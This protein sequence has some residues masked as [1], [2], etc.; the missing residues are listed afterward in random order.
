MSEPGRGV[1]RDIAAGMAQ[2]TLHRIA[3]SAL[4]NAQRNRRHLERGRSI[5]A[6]RGASLGK[7]DSAVIVAAG[8]SVHRHD[9]V[10]ELIRGGY[11][12]AVIATDS[13]MRGC[14]RA[15]LV[16]DLVVTVDPHADRIVRWFGR[17]DLHDGHLEDDYFRRQDM[18]RGFANERR[19]NDEIVALLDRYGSSMRIAL[20]TSAS[21]AVVDRAL[22]TG[23][24]IFWWNPMLD[25]PA[26]DGMSRRLQRLN[27]LPCINAGGNVG[28][29]CWMIADAVLG[30]SR[31]A[32]TGVDFSYYGDTPRSATQYYRELLDLLGEARLDEGFVDIHNPHLDAPFYTDP[33][34]LWY[35]DVFLELLADAECETW[36]CT[37]GGILFGEGIR[38]DTLDSFISLTNAS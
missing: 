6:L 4:E 29:A 9:P 8:P 2:I 14:L 32:L 16:P 28:T 27:G 1:G 15:G 33:A 38:W 20:S 35:R 26:Q 19:A 10:G 17:P 37:G 13:A 18:D 25:D 21:E 5:A 3:E 23:M 7:G 12:G 30:K 34:Y 36:N 24:E 22:A 11:Q 31:V